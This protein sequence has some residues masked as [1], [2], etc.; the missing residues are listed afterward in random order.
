[1][2]YDGEWKNDKREGWGRLTFPDGRA[3][4]GQW[5]SG[6]MMGIGKLQYANGWTYEGEFY[7][8]M[9]HGDGTKTEWYAKT[10]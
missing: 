9:K 3:Y 8:D 6:R 2:E 7:A 10:C 4:E 5:V 1:M